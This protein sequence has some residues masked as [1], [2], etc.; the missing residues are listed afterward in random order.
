MPSAQK[1]ELDIWERCSAE[2]QPA[3][4]Q[5]TVLRL[6]E[7]QEQVATSRL[8]GSFA[9]QAA[10]EVMLEASK[11]PLPQ[12]ARKLHFLLASPFRYPPLPHGSRF[13]TRYEPGIFYGSQTLQ[14]LLAEA[15]YYRLVFW[16]GMERPP[17]KRLL[18]QHTLF[19]ARYRTPRGLRL[20]NPP[21]AQYRNSLRD[22]SHYEGT[23][24]LG[25]HLRDAGIEA[26]EYE[27]ARDPD[28]GLNVALFSPVALMP[29]QRLHEQAWLCETSG[30]CVSFQFQHGRDIHRFP[31]WMFL[32]GDALPTPAT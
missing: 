11:P 30:E 9:R 24:R 17:T 19:R 7:S 10:L 28:A 29:S 4:L 12:A 2:I 13:G 21:F 23:Q 6:V 32:V 15:A 1:S 20:E 27:S 18:T 14:P 8:V 22:P 3:A 16:T 26:I 5:G 25:E 31:I